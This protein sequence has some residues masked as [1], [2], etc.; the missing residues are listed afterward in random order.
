MDKKAVIQKILHRKEIKD[1][2]YATLF[3]LISSFFLVFAIKPAL[4][5]AF[6]LKKEVSDLRKINATYESSILKLVEIQSAL[7]SVRD[8]R[9]LFDTAIPQKPETD[10]FISGIETAA[11]SAGVVYKNLVLAPVNLKAASESSNLKRLTLT[12]YSNIDFKTIDGFLEN[13]INQKRL[14][15][16]KKLQILKEKSD[17]TSSSQLKVIIDLDG[18]YL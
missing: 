14:K 12:L 6:S 13:L 3:F 11:Q 10:S 4:T 15:T 18:Y 16:I 1:Y 8:R 5:I 17:A 9:A 7:E 2:T